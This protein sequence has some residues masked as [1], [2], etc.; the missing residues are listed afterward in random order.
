MR[1]YCKQVELSC[2]RQGT[3]MQK[4]N[5]Q[6][7]EGHNLQLGGASR[8]SAVMHM[9]RMYEPPSIARAGP[10]GSSP[11]EHGLTLLRSPG[12]SEAEIA[13]GGERCP[14]APTQWLT[15]TGARD[16]HFDG[17]ETRHEPREAG[18]DSARLFD[19]VLM[20]RRQSQS[21]RQRCITSTTYVRGALA[22]VAGE[23]AAVQG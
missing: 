18:G 2:Q 16:F 17:Q 1:S 12:T 21:L 5:R 4:R 15:S 13:H 10:A 7:D 20:R 22:R 19:S 11:T 3:M 6:L 9:M 14:A 8:S 23:A